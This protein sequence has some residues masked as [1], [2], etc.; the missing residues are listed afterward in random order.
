MIRADAHH[1]DERRL[2]EIDAAFAAI[3]SRH[4]SDA[5][6]PRNAWKLPLSG[7]IPN[8]PSTAVARICAH[9]AAAEH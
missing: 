4:N 9:N 5:E 8:L 1:V 7:L 6:H 3:K 2:A